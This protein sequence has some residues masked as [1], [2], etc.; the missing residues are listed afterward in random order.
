MTQET[1]SATSIISYETRYGVMKEI[2]FATAER[3]FSYGKWL[4]ASLLTVHAGSL[5]AISQ[6]G[7]K[8]AKLYQA[9][10]P[11]L[12][13]GVAST[14]I[15]GGLAWINFS[16]AANVY[17]KAMNDLRH[18][19]EPNPTKLTRLLAGLTLWVTPLVACLSL[20]L[21]LF[22]AIRATSIL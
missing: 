4:L 18:A 7:E 15:C 9:C 19:Q 1:A 17:V 11:L 3:Q 8:T 6:A 2:Y 16:V 14:L 5:L 13:Y 12:I 21:F 20:G 22:A 10:G